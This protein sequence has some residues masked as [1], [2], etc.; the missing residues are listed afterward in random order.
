MVECRK[1]RVKNK[2]MKDEEKPW[3][4][5]EEMMVR[6]NYVD[7]P[8]PVAPSLRSFNYLT[9]LCSG[10]IENFNLKR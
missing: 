8:F 10:A 7:T 2:S 5:R 1:K 3:Q 6:G 4:R 9:W